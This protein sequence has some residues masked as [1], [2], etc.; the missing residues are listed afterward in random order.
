MYRWVCRSRIGG[1][2]ISVELWIL[3]VWGLGGRYDCDGKAWFVASWLCLIW[4]DL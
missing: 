4:S 2:Q 3:Q 1:R